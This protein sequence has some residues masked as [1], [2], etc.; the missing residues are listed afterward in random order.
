MS[1]S[2][3][4]LSFEICPIILIGGI[5]QNL[6]QQSLPIIALT[7]QQNYNSGLV[8][9]SLQIPPENYFAHF[10]LLPGNKLLSNS[11][12]Q[13]PFA[14]QNVAA[15]AIV[16]NPLNV[17]FI[18]ICPANNINDYTA[19]SGIITALKRS[20]DQHNAAGGM[21][22]ISTPAYTYTYCVMKDFVDVSSGTDK[23]LQYEYRLDFERPLL[24]Q[25]EATNSY[26]ALMGKM[27][28]FLPVVPDANGEIK[29]SSQQLTSDQTG[30]NTLST[31]GFQNLQTGIINSNGKSS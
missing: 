8:S 11:I 17:S 10:L 5:A 21:Y 30:G 23:Q 27:N 24:T 15:N 19:K 14:N 16:G 20:L 25:I 29:W 26:N 6:P 4:Q 3:F 9:G 12:A 28:G 22:N 7:E 13:Y 31:T 18:M 2:N 1:L